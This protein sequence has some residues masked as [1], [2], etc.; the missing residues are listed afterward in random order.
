M[1]CDVHWRP[2][3]GTPPGARVSEVHRASVPLLVLPARATTE[4][5]DLWA[6]MLHE[7]TQKHPEEHLEQVCG[8]RCWGRGRPLL[9]PQFL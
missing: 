4:V 8:Q 3:A 5:C 9:Q 6:V 2:T 7:Y 1:L